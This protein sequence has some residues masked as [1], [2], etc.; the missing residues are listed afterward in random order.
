[1]S[2]VKAQNQ[3]HITWRVKT[4]TSKTTMFINGPEWSNVFSGIT[5]KIDEVM[6]EIKHISS[7]WLLAK[8]KKPLCLLYEWLVNPLECIKI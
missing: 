1:M 7:Q 2:E 8:M 5:S 4:K 3:E 6:D